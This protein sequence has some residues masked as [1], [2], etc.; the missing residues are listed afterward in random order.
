MKSQTLT[1]PAPITYIGKV[2]VTSTS[3][4]AS[5]FYDELNQQQYNALQAFKEQL[6]KENILSNF[7]YTITYIY[8]FSCVQANSTFQIQS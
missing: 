6:T 3:K 5:G 2:K 7:D 1:F 4:D 8:F